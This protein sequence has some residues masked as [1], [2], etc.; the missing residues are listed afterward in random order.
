[1][2]SSF[3]VGSALCVFSCGKPTMTEHSCDLRDD[4]VEYLVFL[5]CK[6]CHRYH[7]SESKDLPS[8]RE[9][10]RRKN[11]IPELMD[12]KFRGKD[13]VHFALLDSLDQ[14]RLNCIKS[15][16]IRSDTVQP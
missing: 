7:R 3:M 14:S 2:F 4:K 12:T 6:S 11:E 8:F 10:I 16:I 5:S 9:L 1:M 15:Y 13:D